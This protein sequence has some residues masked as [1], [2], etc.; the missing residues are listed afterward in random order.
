ME[1]DVEGEVAWTRQGV[2]FDS[3]LSA[4]IGV[5]FTDL[6]AEALTAIKEFTSLRE[7]IFHAD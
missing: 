7:P 6:S 1:L 3:E 2:T 5:R 4:G